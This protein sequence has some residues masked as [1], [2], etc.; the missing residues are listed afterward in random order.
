[1]SNKF[2]FTAKN[3]PT[4]IHKQTKNRSQLRRF[5]WQILLNI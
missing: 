1:M 2:K 5:H 3:L 4:K